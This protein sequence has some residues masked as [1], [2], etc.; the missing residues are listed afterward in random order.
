MEGA[1]FQLVRRGGFVQSEH[2]ADT[3]RKKKTQIFFAAGSVFHKRFKG[4]LYAVG[5]GRHEVYRYGL[6]IFLGVTL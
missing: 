2:Y 4:A 3:G 1:S 6:P 5:N